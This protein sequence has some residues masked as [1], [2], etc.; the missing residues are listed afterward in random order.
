MADI[1]GE[2]IDEEPE[3][4]P[5]VASE[6]ANQVTLFNPLDAEPVQFSRALVSRSENY[7]AL[8]LHLRGILVAGKD[9][10]R[11][12]IAK[13]GTGRNQCEA[14]WSCSYEQNPHH[15]TP[16]TLFSQ[17]GDKALGLL[18]LG[19]SYPDDEDYRRAALKGMVIKDVIIKAF[20]DNGRGQ[21]IS[22][23]MGAASRSQENDDLN[24]TIKKAIKRARMDAVLRLPAIS[25]LFEDD[26]LEEL[27]REQATKKNSTSRR[28]QQ[29]NNRFDT[30]ALLTEWPLKGK[31][32]GQK[33]AGM[34]AGALQW[35]LDN[36]A[37][38]PDIHKAAER[39]MAERAKASDTQ[40]APEGPGSEKTERTA[41]Q[42]E[43]APAPG[44]DDWF[45]QYDEYPEAQ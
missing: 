4:L 45:N 31:L 33:F 26:F 12:H 24:R 41:E 5:A 17:G 38:K 7:D 23:G 3:A 2:I 36:F 27:E 39:V 30:G 11:I 8:A 25:A 14:P 13:R 19:V 34:D 43:A 37:D 40:E 6:K 32:A 16:Q 15:W 9:F 18:G 35:I 20:I 42:G 29:V 22:E 44:L 10:G 21:V 1:E 28:Q